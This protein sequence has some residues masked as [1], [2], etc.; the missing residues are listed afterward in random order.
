M[1]AQLEQAV[2][3]LSAPN[4]SDPQLANQAFNYV[5]SVKDSE[6]GW[7]AAL[8][9]FVRT[10]RASETVRMFCLEILKDAVDRRSQHPEDESLQYIKQLLLEY[11]Q[12]TYGPGSTISDSSFIQNKLC[13]VITLLFVA[14]YTTTWQTFFDDLMALGRSSPGGVWDNL[15][16]VEF[17]MRVSLNVH[18]E[19]ADVL[20]P[21]TPQEGQRN[22]LIKDG[23]R[24]RDM[25]KLVTAWQEIMEEWKGKNNQVVEMGLGTIG[26]WVSWIDISLVVNE[27]MLNQLFQFMDFGGKVRDAAI[28][29]LTE[30][31]G[32]KMKGPDKM[33]LI[34][35]LNVGQI[36]EQIVHSAALQDQKTEDYDTDLAEGTAKLVNAA[37]MDIVLILSKDEMDENNRLR[38]ESLLQMFFPLLLRF[39]TDEYD[40]VSSAVF[41]VTAE[42]LS[43]LR[44]EKKISGGLVP[45]HQAMLQPIL[46]AIVMK[47]KYD[48]DTNWGDEDEQSEEAEFQHLRRQLKT[49]QDAVSAIDECLYID[50]MSQLVEGTF[51]RMAAQGS[52][53]SVDWR[54]VDL[55]LYEMSSFGEMAMRYGGLFAKGQPSGLPAERLVNMLGKMMAS[56]VADHPHP[57]VK[58]KC[59]EIFMRHAA[60]FEV[61]TNYIPQALEGFNKCIH[62]N[63]IRVR[64]RS[65]YLFHRFVKSL[66]QYMGEVAEAIMRAMGD[67]LVIRAELP[68]DKNDADEMSSESKQGENTTFE[69]QLYLFEAV[70][71]MCSVPS[72]PVENQAMLIKSVTTPLFSDIEQS[73]VAAESGDAGATLQIHHDIMALGILGK[74]FSDW[75]AGSRLDKACASE[76]A[77]EFGR[78]TEAILVALERLSRFSIVREAA[79]FS[80]ARIVGVLSSNILPSLPRWISGLMAKSSTKEEISMFLKLLNQLIHGFK[81]VIYEMLNELFTPLLQRVFVSLSEPVNGTDDHVQLT[82]LRREFLNFILIILNNDLGQVLFSEANRDQFETV[83][84]AIEHYAKETSDPA[85]EKI[86]FNLLNKMSF[87]FGPATGLPP[88]NKAAIGVAGVNPPQQ[89]PLS[90]FENLMNQRFSMLC[91]EVPYSSGFNPKDAQAKIVLGEVASLQKMLYFKLG[92]AFLES[93]RGA[94]FP[95]IGVNRGVEEYCDAVRR[96]EGKEFK[97][98]FQKFVQEVL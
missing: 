33:D 57:I 96:M 97:G 53:G 86:A 42:L 21:R 11:V 85:T 69:S 16:G 18:D 80:F 41:S 13:Q 77:S 15:P 28:G 40:D 92:E 51:D 67:L 82:D 95:R 79:R 7:Q 17:F 19:V 56:N 83:L 90:G 61:H 68:K 8:P 84:K 49:M 27:L 38:A 48:E 60:F 71:C 76:V 70:G 32:K 3:I 45:T 4:R 46:N 31:V 64:T 55:A 78:V 93:L 23:V 14:T 65:W 37:T 91:W 2:Q 50:L 88:T 62:H 47:T 5:H 94:I 72:L 29:A 63:H 34:T 75:V 44:K 12:V 22:V 35:F 20:I 74:G 36:A 10:S 73:L 9:L 52:N 87:V 6:D 26:R 39:F 98:F 89:Q 24:N 81:N 30:I 54:D 43:L 25:R 1:D 58:L 66:R 59:M